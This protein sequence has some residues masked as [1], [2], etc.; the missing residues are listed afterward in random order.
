M[1][2][3]VG[4]VSRKGWVVI[5]APIRKRLGLAYGSA[6]RI[7]LEGDRII[8]TPEKNPVE[9]CFGKLSHGESLTDLLLEERKKDRIREE[10][11][12]RL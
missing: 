11:K 4:K 9:E 10:E 3:V 7:R 12:I 1:M 8:L 5:P 2:E 6:V